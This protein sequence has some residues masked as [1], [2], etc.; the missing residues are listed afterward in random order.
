MLRENREKR[1]YF[2]LFFQTGA[3]KAHLGAPFRL[4]IIPLTQGVELLVSEIAPRR[5]LP[6]RR[7]QDKNTK[8]ARKK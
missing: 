5:E 1:A 3:Q 4:R 7:A 6:L 2:A 8:R